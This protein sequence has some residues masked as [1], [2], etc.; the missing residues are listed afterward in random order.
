MQEKG[1]FTVAA[2]ALFAGWRQ[3]RGLYALVLI[4]SGL[5]TAHG[6]GP[7]NFL[8]LHYF[9]HVDAQG[10]TRYR[11]PLFEGESVPGVTEKAF[12]EFNSKS[13]HRE[14]F[15]GPCWSLPLMESKAFLVDSE[16]MAIH[17][18][19]GSIDRMMKS[20]ESSTSTIFENS[21]GWKAT[22]KQDEVMVRQST[23][24]TYLFK[25]GRIKQ[26]SSSTGTTYQWFFKNGNPYQL[27]DGFGRMILELR[28]N[29]LGMVEEIAWNQQQKYVLTYT[30]VPL[31][32]RIEG[33][34]VVSHLAKG[35]EQMAKAGE[36]ALRLDWNPGPRVKPS[37]RLE[38]P[39]EKDFHFSWDSKSLLALEDQTNR[40]QV[41]PIGKLD[42]FDVA[43][44]KAV[45]KNT[46]VI[47]SFL[48]DPQ[49]G[50]STY[51]KGNRTLKTYVF[52]A[53]SRFKGKMRKVE[54]F[55]DNC[56]LPSKHFS[57]NSKAML[58]RIRDDAN[59]ET[60]EKSYEEDGTTIKEIQYRTRGDLTRKEVYKSGKIETLFIAPNILVHVHNG[61]K[62][63]EILQSE[64]NQ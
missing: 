55:E 7:D 32:K 10:F 14:G 27:K 12:L 42:Y 53:T 9:P 58:I 33:L 31:V 8:K 3:L 17:Y 16:T 4:L 19:D 25:N 44:V 5:T 15:L 18:P 22:V 20:G 57:Y 56:E 40:Y 63:V 43:R 45:D 29:R 62:V 26:Y 23:G 47:S 34:N 52:P 54:R 37:C 60:V 24:A 41:H 39:G 11:F 38:R 46:G 35:L 64:G 1:S 13:Y 36:T 51:S 61:K 6:E 59:G 21:M 28:Y 30:Q 48:F 50:V 2:A 49:K